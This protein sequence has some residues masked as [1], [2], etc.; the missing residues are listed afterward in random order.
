MS[1]PG[2]PTVPCKYCKRSIDA[3]ATKCPECQSDL[4]P[5]PWFNLEGWSKLVGF[6]IA[7]ITVASLGSDK[8]S[9]LYLVLTGKDG[10]TINL[11]FTDAQWGE[12]TPS[13]EPGEFKAV[14]A[15]VTNFGHGPG[16]LFASVTCLG[17]DLT[18][19]DKNEVL[20]WRFRAEAPTLIDAGKLAFVQLQ[21]KDRSP[22]VYPSRDVALA[23]WRKEKGGPILPIYTC[24]FNYGDKH[25]FGLRGFTDP[26]TF[27]ASALEPRP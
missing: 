8:L 12:P 9:A 22:I 27:I 11:A 1:M 15:S 24:R 7:L 3:G 18:K 17:E 6:V 20:T 21:F 4:R 13:G 16:L 5:K 2:A 14:T 25:G 19:G 26:Q 10:A 23:Q